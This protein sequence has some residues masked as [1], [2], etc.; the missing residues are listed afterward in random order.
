[1]TTPQVQAAMQG[2]AGAM[3]VQC[4]YCHVP[5]A[6]PPAPAAAP[7]GAAAPAGRGRGGPPPLDFAS[8]A[9]PEKAKARLMLRMVNDLNAALPAAVS[10]SA[11]DVTQIQCATCHRGVA[12]PA[13][14]GNVVNQVMLTKGEAAAV[15]RYKELRTQYYGSQAYDFSEPVLPRL[16]AQSLTNNKPDDALAYL[17]LNLEFYPKSS[18]T[19]V[20]LSQ[21]HARKND[22]AAA[23]KDLEQALSLDPKNA[24]AQRQLDQLKAAP[25]AQ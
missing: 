9:K 21:V 10:K 11:T 13:Q 15:G 24:Q 7:E 6:P 14:I 3:G 8:D 25:A 17:K 5:G 4:N 18:Q 20:G 23:I 1:M 12:I 16:A 22:R 2:I 19:Y